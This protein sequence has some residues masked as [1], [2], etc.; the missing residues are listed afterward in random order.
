LTEA[1][2]WLARQCSRSITVDELYEF[3]DWRRDP[4]NAAAFASV[5]ATWRS[6][7]ELANRPA[8]RAVTEAA[9]QKWPARRA[10]P[11]PSVRLRWLYGI[12]AA[13]AVAA[14]AGWIFFQLPP[15]FE[16]QVGQQRLVTLDDG[17]R[18]RLNT[19][20]KLVVRY[21]RNERRVELVHGE[22]FF[23]AA[24]DAGRPF[25][26]EADG[27]RVRALGTKFDVRRDADLVRVTLL[28]GR[29]QVAKADQP[30]SATLTPNQQLTVTAKG[31][32]PVMAADAAEA[33]GWTTGRL[34][35]HETPL[36][37]AVAEV[38]RYSDEK[39][40]LD[41]PASLGRKP[42]S[43]A[44]NTGDT[45][46]FVSTIQVFLDLKTSESGG[47]VHLSPKAETPPA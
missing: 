36:E 47:V 44:F 11:D 28:E 3:R 7:G 8:I 46:A 15:T 24:H 37:E 10:E 31:I 41:G 27:T 33:A 30:T 25:V 12:A 5:E 45:H 17:S 14:V 1:A 42:I 19:D 21:R 39:V 40:V 26:V 9:L 38:N 16:T 29:V 18:V 20:S 23:E 35:F 43:G 6:S 4:D 2:D 13:G 22:A 32:S 34:I